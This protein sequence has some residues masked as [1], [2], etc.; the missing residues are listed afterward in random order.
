MVNH[1]GRLARAA[2]FF[3]F[4]AGAFISAGFLKSVFL[5]GKSVARLARV[6]RLNVPGS[7]KYKTPDSTGANLALAKFS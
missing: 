3:L 1:G 5:P 6:N 4:S 7:H 2:C